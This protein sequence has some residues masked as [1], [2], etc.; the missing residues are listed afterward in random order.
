MT[1]IGYARV[2]STGQKL[3]VQ[4]EKLEEQGC[5]R[6]Y[7]EKERGT[8]SNRLELTKCLDY[9]REGDTLVVTKL[10]RLARSTL[11]LCSIAKLLEDKGVM[12]KVIDQ[13]IDTSG[14]TGRLLFNML[15]SIAQF[16]TEIRKERQVDGIKKAKENGVAFGRSKA[17]TKEQVDDLRKSRKNGVLIKKLMETYGLSKKTIYNY[18]QLSQERAA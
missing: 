1:L 15:S 6:T 8:T 9:V 13:N 5:E 3:D 18:L 11:D 16:E 2:S 14:S 4:L 17:L 7:Q 10:D 12:L